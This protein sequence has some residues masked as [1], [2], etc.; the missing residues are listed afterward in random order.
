[1]L[2]QRDDPDFP[3]LKAHPVSEQE[4]DEL[5]RAAFDCERA[6]KAGIAQV[7]ADTW[8]LAQHLY[9][10]H[11]QRLW[12]LLGF[13]KLE[14][15]LS[16]PE[17]ELSHR[18]FFRLVQVWRDLHVTKQLP[19]VALREIEVSK[20]AVILPAVM[21]G[22]VEPEK[23]LDDAKALSRRELQRQYGARTRTPN[24]PT[25]GL[26][27]AENRAEDPPSPSA[28][29]SPGDR[30]RLGN[31]QAGEVIAIA[32]EVA[33]DTGAKERVPMDWLTPV[34]KEAP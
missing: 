5:V 10:L 14:A 9:E 19:P 20:A 15:F 2:P 34:D 26:K 24:R 22:N 18:S 12:E 3:K 29:L 11:E 27:S 17:I 30:V 28:P 16:Q 7:H 21:S 31:G 8:T 13:S 25:E 23:A 4:R 32:V 33:F 1:M 6:I